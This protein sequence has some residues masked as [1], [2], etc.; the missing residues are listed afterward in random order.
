M[1]DINKE[2]PLIT[3]I[4]GIYNGEKYLRECLDSVISQDY[5]NLEVILINDGSRD[6]SGKIIDEYAEKDQRIKVIHQTNSGV[7]VSRNNALDIS[8]GEYICILDQDDILSKDYVSYFY[9]LI[10]EN[11]GEI[12]LTREADKFFDKVVESNIEDSIEIWTGEKASIEMLYH[13]III[14]PWNKMIKRELI[15]KNNIKFNTNFFNGEGFAFSIECYQAA[16]KVVVGKRKVYHYRVGDPESGASKF[17]IEWI[18]SSIN[19][20]QYIK[21]KLEN[22]SHELINAWE[23]SNWHTH[24]DALNVMVGC[25]AI[26]KYRNEYESIKRKCQKDALCAI[27]APVSIQQKLRGVLF[28]LNPY[29]ASKIINKF[30]LRK[31]NSNAK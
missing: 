1:K 7:S 20:Q 14:A 3:V 31:F 4:V 9:S 26:D 5:R 10:K 12:A 25:N 17:K 15:V 16:N 11:N 23:F 28:K 27:K 29:I 24:C 6:S 13:K 30:R 18:N 19:A 21:N 2:N 22:S 8:N